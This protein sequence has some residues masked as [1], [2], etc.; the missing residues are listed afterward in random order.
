MIGFIKDYLGQN[1]QN[2]QMTADQ[3]D[4]IVTACSSAASPPA[5]TL[6]DHPDDQHDQHCRSPQQGQSNRPIRSLRTPMKEIITLD[7]PRELEEVKVGRNKRKKNN[8]KRRKRRKKYE[9]E[10]SNGKMSH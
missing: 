9:I 6:Q 3:R 4:I 1:N 2:A 5:Q 10:L 7:D 8:G